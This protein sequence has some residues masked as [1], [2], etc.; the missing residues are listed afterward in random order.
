MSLIL[1]IGN[2]IYVV[3]TIL[4]D[5]INAIGVRKIGESRLNQKRRMN[6]SE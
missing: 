2:V 3:T 1:M 5:V 4:L 6:R